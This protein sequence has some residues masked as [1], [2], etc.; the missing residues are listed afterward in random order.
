MTEKESEAKFAEKKRDMIGNL[1]NEITKAF[2]KYHPQPEVA[3]YVLEMIKF[4]V[5]NEVYRRQFIK[6]TPIQPTPI[7]PT[8][9]KDK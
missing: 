3:V 9:P 2:M 1:H 5:Q 7:K 6:P 8:K 4:E